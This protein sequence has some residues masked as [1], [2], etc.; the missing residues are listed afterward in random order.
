MKLSRGSEKPLFTL[1]IHIHK[2][3]NN[4]FFYFAIVLIC[5]CV[6]FFFFFFECVKLYNLHAIRIVYFVFGFFLFISVFYRHESCEELKKLLLL[7]ESVCGYHVY[8]IR[9]AQNSLLHRQPDFAECNTSRYG[10]A[11]VHAALRLWRENDP[12]YMRTQF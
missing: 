4:F 12:R 2:Y 5:M 1:C 10:H 6:Y 11:R 3:T 8:H 9:S 7:S